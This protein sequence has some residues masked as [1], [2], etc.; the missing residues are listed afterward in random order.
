MRTHKAHSDCWHT[1]THTHT[2]RLFA[3]ERCGKEWRRSL[4]REWV[5]QGRVGKRAPDLREWIEA[6][7][8]DVPDVMLDAVPGVSYDPESKIVLAD[9]TTV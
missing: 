7:I 5:G 6:A 2:H 1:H 4:D 8:H 3:K 9:G